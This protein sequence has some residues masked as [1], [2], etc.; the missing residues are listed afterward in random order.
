MFYPPELLTWVEEVSSHLAHLSHSQAQ[1]LAW[2]SFAVTIVQSSGLSHV[3]VFLAHLLGRSE[4]TIRQRLRE[5]LYDAG[6]KRGSKRREIDVQ[7][8]FG[9]FFHWIVSRWNS[10][11][12]R[13]FLA[14]D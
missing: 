5:T 2:Y 1:M 8:C 3:S 13:L 9:P 7:L 10:P 4:E 11:D 6:D 12:D 14:L